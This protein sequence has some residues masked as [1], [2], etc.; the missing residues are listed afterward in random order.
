MQPHSSIRYIHTAL[1]LLVLTLL[2]KTI[3]VIALFLLPSHEADVSL[4]NSFH[5]PY[6]QVNFHNMLEST[7]NTVQASQHKGTANAIDIDS[8]ILTALYGKGGYGYVI[9]APKK[10]PNK[11]TLLS[12]GESYQ[13]YKLKSLFLYYALF[14]KMG[15]EYKLRLNSAPVTVSSFVRPVK[16]G[17]SN[18]IVQRAQINSYVHNPSNIWKDISIQQ[19][20]QNGD[21]KGFEVTRIRQGSPFALLGLQ[22]GDLIIRVNNINLKSYK[23]R[24]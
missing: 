16:N 20:G 12:V 10:N 1:I 15:R 9:V 2:A 14:S 7:K 13:G 4:R 6:L 18:Y 8:L 24:K 5:I 3:S 19:I 22:V 11:T 17:T 21:F 23:K